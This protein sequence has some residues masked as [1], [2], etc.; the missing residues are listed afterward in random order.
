MF[1]LLC[2]VRAGVVHW[3]T[4]PESTIPTVGASGA[5]A[6]VLGAYFVLFSQSR[7]VVMV[8][9]LFV[10]FFFE[11]PAVLYLGVWALSQVFSGSLALAAPA[12]VGGVAWWAHLGGFVTG[13][14]L[15]RLFIR[16]RRRAARD[17]GVLFTLTELWTACA[18]VVNGRG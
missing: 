2:G 7:V 11:L 14:V 15:H 12:D 8:P 17:E 10:P 5:I 6:G 18:G 3:F 16:R 1:Y 9:V 4:N 13:I